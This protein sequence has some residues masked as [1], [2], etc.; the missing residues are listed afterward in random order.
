MKKLIMILSALLCLSMLFVSCATEST[1]ELPAETTAQAE[2]TTETTPTET[3]LETEPEPIPEDLKIDY[4]TIISQWSQ[5]ISFEDETEVDSDISNSLSNLYS[6]SSYWNEYSNYSENYD[7]YR[8]GDLV[9]FSYHSIT[10][11]TAYNYEK[12]EDEDYTIHAYRYNVFNM[13]SGAEVA[14]TQYSYHYYPNRYGAD[15]YDYA[16]NTV[17]H[18]T[19]SLTHANYG[20]IRIELINHE[21][22]DETH[23]WENVYTYNY[24]DQDGNLLVDGLKNTDFEVISYSSVYQTIIRIGGKYFL[25]KDGEIVARLGSEMQ[26]RLDFGVDEYNGLQYKWTN[27]TVQVLDTTTNRVTVDWCYNDYFNQRDGY[28]TTYILGNGNI[29]FQ[30]NCYST[31]DEGIQ[32][33]YSYYAPIYT[34]VDAKTGKVTDVTPTY[35]IDGV[36]YECSIVSLINNVN[37]Q[38]TGLSLKDETYQLAEILLISDGIAAP[39]TTLAI[40]NSELQVVAT[41]DRFLQDQDSVCGL[42]ENGDLLIHTEYGLYYTVDVNGNRSEKVQ[43]FV[44][45]SNVDQLITGGFLA[46]D[47]ILYNDNLKPLVNV[48][49]KYNEYFLSADG[50][51]AWSIEDNCYH[52]LSIN[53]AGELEIKHYP[54]EGTYLT[55]FTFG[56]CTVYKSINSDSWSGSYEPYVYT[57]YNAQGRAIKTLHGEACTVTNGMLKLTSGSTSTYYILK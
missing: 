35:E 26:V 25:V 47:G 44:A 10:Y 7:V 14:R 53:G 8:Q 40:L 55:S 27:D 12:G 20:V 46:T 56:D 50:L 41:L 18:S 13:E 22:N 15:R 5:Y 17:S 54:E 43:L 6:Y 28:L 37:N 51:K 36:S 3:D 52:Y 34:L 32:F 29:L 48:S 30:K 23:Q 42:L 4:D 49:Q 19:P 1:E 33:N 57:V 24:Y 9:L 16:S 39:K 38:G 2:E 45:P 31:D 21:Y 11:E